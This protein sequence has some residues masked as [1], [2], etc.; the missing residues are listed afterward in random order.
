MQVCIRRGTDWEQ[1]RS[2]LQQHID[3]YARFF[4]P[5]FSTGMWFPHAQ[6][7]ASRRPDFQIYFHGPLPR[8]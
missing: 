8:Q 5:L 2:P 1:I 3:K 7:D 6:A 4:Y